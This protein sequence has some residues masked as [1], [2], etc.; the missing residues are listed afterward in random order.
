MKK[1]ICGSE[2]HEKKEPCIFNENCNG[3]A[4]CV[5]GLITVVWC[6]NGECAFGKTENEDDEY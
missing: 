3:C 1:C 4:L 2:R 5:D 6:D